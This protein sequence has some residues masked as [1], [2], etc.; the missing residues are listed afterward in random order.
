LF[1]SKGLSLTK[2]LLR[3]H[4]F[5]VKNDEKSLKNLKKRQKTSQNRESL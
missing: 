3:L 2:I 1:V 5:L 4:A